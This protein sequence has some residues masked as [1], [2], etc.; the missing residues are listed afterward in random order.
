MTWKGFVV[1]VMLFKAGKNKVLAAM[2]KN[3]LCVNIEPVQE[4]KDEVFGN[5]KGHH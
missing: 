2:R 4:P 3:D 5:E 1:G